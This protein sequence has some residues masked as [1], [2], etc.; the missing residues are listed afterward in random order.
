[1][2]CQ[3]FKNNVKNEIIRINMQYINHDAPI[4]VVLNI[5]NS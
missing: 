3:N 5:D 4:I 1:M 2:F